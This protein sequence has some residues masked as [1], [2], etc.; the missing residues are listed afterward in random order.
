M[1]RELH[2]QKNR[3]KKRPFSSKFC[4]TV[5]LCN[6]L[7][8]LKR[9]FKRMT[10]EEEYSL[11]QRLKQ[12]TSFNPTQQQ[13]LV[14]CNVMSGDTVRS[15]LP[16]MVV[17]L[18][19]G[20]QLH[21]ELIWVSLLSILKGSFILCFSWKSLFWSD[22]WPRNKRLCCLVCLHLNV[23]SLPCIFY[24]VTEKLS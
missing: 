10:S 14:F 24:F 17:T 2:K 19:S 4:G 7:T 11:K 1:C 3:R 18:L 9:I 5:L 8:P 15:S 16:V 12:N 23:Q 20:L 22:E 6:I 13:A 21:G